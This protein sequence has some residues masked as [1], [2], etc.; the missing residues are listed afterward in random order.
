[1]E[2]TTSDPSITC[3]SSAVEDD[4]GWTV[5]CTNACATVAACRALYLVTGDANDSIDGPF[6]NI[7][8]VCQSNATILDVDAAVTVVASADAAC[9]GSGSVAHYARLGVQCPP[10]STDKVQIGDGANG[11]VFD[12]YYTEC[13]LS[14]AAAG[15]LN[16]IHT[17]FVR[18]SCDSTACSALPLDPLLVQAD[19]DNFQKE[20]VAVAPSVATSLAHP[21][22]TAPTGTS[23][24]T[25]T[26]RFEGAWGVLRR[27]TD[28]ST[29]TACSDTTPPIVRLACINSRIEQQ[30]G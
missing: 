6:A 8:F 9:A 18:E 13:W 28:T 26:A 10:P 11:F 14:F 19:L 30:R 7:T 3:D 25:V 1:V 2:D 4:N 27:A 16:G 15:Y 5:T 22:T 23:L 24:F 17:C 12:N 29:I 21:P 20:C